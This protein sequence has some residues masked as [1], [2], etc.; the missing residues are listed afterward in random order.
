M[1]LITKVNSFKTY[2]MEGMDKLSEEMK[3]SDSSLDEE[4][5]YIG[6]T[7]EEEDA[8]KEAVKSN[9]EEYLAVYKMLEDCSCPQRYLQRRDMDP[10]PG[11]GVL[12]PTLRSKCLDP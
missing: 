7:T 8:I 11:G 1:E 3:L 6:S 2:R 12:D 5:R 9:E 10:D 4:E